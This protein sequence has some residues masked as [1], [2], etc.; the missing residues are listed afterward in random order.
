MLDDLDGGDLRAGVLGVSDRGLP[1]RLRVQVE[2][3]QTD[4]RVP[5]PRTHHL[6]FQRGPGDAGVGPVG[7]QL[8]DPSP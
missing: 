1:Q 8:A 2:R 4:G 5:Q 6:A 7:Q 3:W